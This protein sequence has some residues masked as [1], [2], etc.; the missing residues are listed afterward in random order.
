MTSTKHIQIVNPHKCSGC[1]ACVNVC[2]K[3]CINMTADALGCVYPNV[4]TK[5]CIECGACVKVC[6]FHNPAVPLEPQQC[7]AAVNDKEDERMRSSSGGV[8]IALARD[9]I[10]RGGVVFGAEFDD[11]WNVHH[12]AAESIDE[13]P[14]M[15]GS[16]YVQSST[17]E[18]FAQA[19]KFLNE[20]REVLYTGTPCQIA[21]LKHF[22][23]KDY[24]NL[25]TVEVI[26][27][28]VPAPAVWLTYLKETI[29]RPQGDEKIRFRNSPI[30]RK[31]DTRIAGVNFRDKR[32]GWKKYG[33][34][35]TLAGAC[36][37]EKNTVSPSINQYFNENAY[38]KVFLRNW[39][40]RPSCYAC[41]TKG[42]RSHADLTIGDFW[43]VEHYPS[44][45]DDD[46]GTSCVVCR[47]ER[48]I[49]AIK[50][51]GISVADCEYADI[52]KG[53]PRIE[54]SVTETANALRFKRLFLR[55][56][57]HKALYNMEHISF[58][59]RCINFA[60]RKLGI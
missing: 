26:C 29:N 2:P 34:A 24:V 38:M 7:F 21:G 41:Q 8:F 47:T 45:P 59:R 60:K 58:L 37:G 20:G 51:S 28:G 12:V 11:N 48:G 36:D 39:S 53:N 35:L 55:K 42:G 3:Q 1:S 40:L 49:E 44:L 17:G 33:F 50:S 23:K 43:G 10:S 56:G 22:L 32:N 14:P 46:H 5:R 4:D 16:K 54:S 30:I 19:R 52:L 31:V 25:L 18:T 13:V 15:M 6:P 9:I 57:F 27:H